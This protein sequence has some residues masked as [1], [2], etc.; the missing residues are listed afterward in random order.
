MPNAAPTDETLDQANSLLIAGRFKESEV[1]FTRLLDSGKQRAQALYGL[2]LIRFHNGELREAKDLLT[3]CSKIDP[4][5]ANCYY[6]LG[7]IDEKNE[8]KVPDTVEFFYRRALEI[9]PNH[10]GARRKLGLQAVSDK[11]RQGTSSSGTTPGVPTPTPTEY[12]FYPLLQRDANALARHSVK[13]IESLDM[14]VRTKARAYLGQILTALLIAISA[15]LVSSMLVETLRSGGSRNI[16]SPVGGLLRATVPSA[17]LALANF[18]DSLTPLIVLAAIVYFARTLIMAWTTT[19]TFGAG[20]VTITS[21]WLRRRIQNVELYR[22][23]DLEISQTFWNTWTGD[24]SIVLYVEGVHGR[25]AA[26]K[27]RLTGVARIEDL[28]QIFERLRNLILL[29]RTGTWGKGVIY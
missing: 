12:G 23:I 15:A 28:R 2:S 11:T 3:E 18:V 27:V 19:V 9:N 13:L 1:L 22:T 24:G 16:A 8:P 6:Y 26:V 20:R 10:F 5:N 25:R 21:G 4:A 17:A 29:L 14:S 7:E